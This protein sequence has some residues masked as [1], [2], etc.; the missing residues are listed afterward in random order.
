MF[1]DLNF[2]ILWSSGPKFLNWPRPPK[3]LKK[4]SWPSQSILFGA[5]TW[6]WTLQNLWQQPYYIILTPSWISRLDQTFRTL[7]VPWPAVIAWLESLASTRAPVMHQPTPGSAPTQIGS[8]QMTPTGLH[9]AA[10]CFWWQLWS[11]TCFK[12]FIELDRRTYCNGRRINK[13]FFLLKQCR[14]LWSSG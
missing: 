11:T 7:A 8:S 3:K 6:S 13:N 5:S 1:Y 2:F 12:L 9:S 14:A 10:W 4:P